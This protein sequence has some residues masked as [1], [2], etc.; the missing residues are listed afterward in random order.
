MS[1][2]GTY[3]G[4]ADILKRTDP[5][6]KIATI[7]EQMNKLNPILQDA[8]AV[9]GNLTHGHMTTIRTGLPS[10][11]WRRFYEGVQP[12]KSAT[13]Q[14]TDTCGNLEAYSEVDK[15]LADMSTDVAAFRMSEATAH[16]EGMNQTMATTLFYGNTNTDPEQFLG[17]AP[18]FSLTSAGNGDQIVAGGGSGDDNM[19]IWI[20]TWSERTCHLIYPK[21]SKAGLMYEDLGRDTKVNSDG[22]MYEVYRSH[23]KWT[24][25]LSVRDWRFISRIANIDESALATYNTGSDTS[26]KLIDLLV[27]GLGKLYNTDAGNTVI[28]CNRTIATALNKMAMNKTNVNLTIDTFGGKPVTK[29]WGYPIRVCDALHATEATV[30]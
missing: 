6:D 17:L 15:G 10:A 2:V 29:F 22:S 23:F 9:E 21:G 13:R 12:T 5:N 25:G 1:T 4:L 28:Y 30:S 27:E 7:I 18:R 20:V 3:L 26:P 16:M 11:T 24:V 19:S 8:I 14:V